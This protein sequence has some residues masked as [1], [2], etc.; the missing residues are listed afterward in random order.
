MEDAG[1]PPGNVQIKF[2]G[3]PA[4]VS[5]VFTKVMHSRVQMVSIGSPVVKV[6]RV[7]GRQSITRTDTVSTLRQPGIPLYPENTLYVT[8]P[9]SFLGALMVMA[10]LFISV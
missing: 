3:P 2:C 8:K 6:T 1:E 9:G 7:T 10:G 4:A 5:V